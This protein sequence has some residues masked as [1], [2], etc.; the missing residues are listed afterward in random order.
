M[1]R[2]I[3]AGLTPSDASKNVS[4]KYILPPANR[5]NREQCLS[6]WQMFLGIMLFRVILSAWIS[7]ILMADGL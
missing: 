3:V 1:C 5:Y 7:V 6:K 4:F 2:V